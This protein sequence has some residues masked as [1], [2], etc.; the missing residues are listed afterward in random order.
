MKITDIPKPYSNRLHVL[1]IEGRD[2]FYCETEEMAKQLVAMLN[3]A[4]LYGWVSK[5]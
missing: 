3:E 2:L 5:K 1:T 4:F